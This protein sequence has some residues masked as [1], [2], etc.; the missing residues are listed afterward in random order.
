LNFLNFD[1][2]FEEYNS[3]RKQNKREIEE[4]NRIVLQAE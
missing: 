2:G 1:Q 4:V 3:Q